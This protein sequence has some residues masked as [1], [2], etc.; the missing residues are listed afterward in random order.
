MKIWITYEVPT[1]NGSWNRKTT[2]VNTFE[3]AEQI[4][5]FMDRNGYHLIDVTRD[6]YED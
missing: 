3:E 1:M 2:T 4:C 6:V 5:N